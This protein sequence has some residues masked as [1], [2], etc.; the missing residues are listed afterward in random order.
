MM[1]FVL[2][3]ISFTVA[4]LLASVIGC[5]VMLNPKVMKWYVKYVMKKMNDFEDVT[6]DLFEAKGL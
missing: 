2:M 1:A 3:T 5:V 4:I 6:E